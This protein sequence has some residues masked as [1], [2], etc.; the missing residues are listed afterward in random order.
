[1]LKLTAKLKSEAQLART[2]NQ[3]GPCSKHEKPGAKMKEERKENEGTRDKGLEGREQ[4]STRTLQESQQ[5]PGAV[6][7]EQA[8]PQEAVAAGPCNCQQPSDRC[9]LHRHNLVGH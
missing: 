7:S 4:V 8:P 6:S 5:P 1:M 3:E 9:S 2:K